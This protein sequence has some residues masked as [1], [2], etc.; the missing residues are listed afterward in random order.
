MCFHCVAVFERICTV[1]GNYGYLNRTIA[2]FEKNFQSQNKKNK[3]KLKE[4]QKPAKA[5][6]EPG[7]TT[8]S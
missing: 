4:D 6:G 7:F 5:G 8:K 3:K 1:S 2:D